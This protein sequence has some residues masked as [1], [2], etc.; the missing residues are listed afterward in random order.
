MS[1]EAVRIFSYFHSCSISLNLLIK[2]FLSWTH[3]LL[4]TFY[5]FHFVHKKHVIV[6][7]QHFFFNFHI[8]VD[9]LYSLPLYPWPVHHCGR[10][11][12]PMDNSFSVEAHILH[13]LNSLIFQ[14][15]STYIFNPCHCVKVI[16]LIL[17]F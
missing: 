1:K 17:E 11:H 13:F 14:L 3:H 8:Q 2:L 16:P 9:D 4:P 7:P 12:S 15:L 5:S 6:F 10:W